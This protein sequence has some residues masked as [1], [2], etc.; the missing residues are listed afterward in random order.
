MYLQGK[1]NTLI[2]WLRKK[3]KYIH[4]V[5]TTQNIDITR[6]VEWG[7]KMVEDGPNNPGMELK[8]EWLE[9][10][11]FFKI[12]IQKFEPSQEVLIRF[13][14]TCQLWRG[15]WRAL[16]VGGL[17]S[18]S[19]RWDW[20]NWKWWW[21]LWECENVRFSCFFCCNE[22]S[23]WWGFTKHK[24]FC[25]FLCFLG[26]MAGQGCH[27][28]RPDHLGINRSVLFHDMIST[29]NILCWEYSSTNHTTLETMVPCWGVHD[30]DR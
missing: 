4:S 22:S 12:S 16:L 26:G 21:Q 10:V 15:G 25:S 19:G 17:S 28:H 30:S 13:E 20:F 5:G 1:R 24:S 3:P 29:E 9:Q 7:N 14:W 2:F 8:L 23:I 6:R 27:L 11:E 18:N